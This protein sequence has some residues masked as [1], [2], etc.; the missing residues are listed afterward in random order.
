MST[1]VTRSPAALEARC[2]RVRAP[3][4]VGYQSPLTELRVPLPAHTRR[5]IEFDADR[6]EDELSG[7]TASRGELTA[8]CRTDVQH[9]PSAGPSQRQTLNAQCG[10][11]RCRGLIELI[12]R[13]LDE[14]RFF[15]VERRTYHSP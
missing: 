13:W 1:T 10:T 8:V 9:S 7:K 4:L 11:D 3:V 14:R 12:I 15:R 5:S 2:R 6:G